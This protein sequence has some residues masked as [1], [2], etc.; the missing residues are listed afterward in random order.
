MI[1]QQNKSQIIFF[2]IFMSLLLVFSGSAVV[3]A[4]AETGCFDGDYID[5]LGTGVVNTA[6]LSCQLEEHPLELL[7]VF[8]D[9][10]LDP[11]Q[12]WQQNINDQFAFWLFDVDADGDINLIIDFHGEDGVLTA[13]MFDDQDG[14]GVVAFD[15]E[16]GRLLIRESPYW[17]MRVQAEDGWW[18]QDELTNFNLNI[19]IDGAIKGAFG[20]ELYFD[21]L[22]NDGLIDFSID[23]MD[24]NRNG[25]PETQIIQAT[26]PV[27][28]SSGI[29]RTLL[30]V[31][32]E[33]DEI[34]PTAQLPWP[35]LNLDAP[36]DIVKTYNSGLAPIQLDWAN[37]QIDSLGEFVASRGNEGNW[38]TYS[39]DRLG[40]DPTQFANFEAPF[41]FY[42]LAD[43]GDG[44]PELQIR[45]EHYPADDGFMAN[46]LKRPLPYTNQNVRYSWDQ[47]NDGFWDYKIDTIGRVEAPDTIAIGE[48][49]FLSFNTDT[50]PQTIVQ[51]SWDAI[52]FVAA[53]N[54]YPSTEGIYEWAADEIRELWITGEDNTVPEAFKTLPLGMRG[55][56]SL[57]SVTAPQLYLS[58]I[59]GKLH[60]MQAN[61][62]FWQIN[63]TQSLQ[64]ANLDRDPYL[65]QWV[66]M[67]R[68]EVTERLNW[69]DDFLL[70]S[71][72]DQLLIKEI[73]P[74]PT[75]PLFAP[76][77]TPEAWAVL[78]QTLANVAFSVDPT[79]LSTAFDQYDGAVLEMSGI[80]V[81]QIR[82]YPNGFQII[83]TVRPNFQVSGDLPWDDSFSETG[84]VQLTYDGRWQIAPHLA[85]FVVDMQL[86]DQPIV[87]GETIPI[88]ISAELFDDQPDSDYWLMLTANEGP[89]LRTSFAGTYQSV[90]NWQVD[91]ETAVSLRLWVEDE[92]GAVLTETAV[93]V[94]VAPAPSE[95]PLNFFTTSDLTL[96]LGAT[97]LL[98]FAGFL[99]FA[100]KF[101]LNRNQEEVIL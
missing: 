55:D 3:A 58:P 22:E 1:V 48:L 75:P 86:P 11:S 101:A 56:Y 96:Y 88:Q 92:D 13:S 84:A 7:I 74:L 71:Q 65:D 82:P 89:L 66:Q 10:S 49:Q 37:G 15:V 30:M 24:E 90:L 83:G 87:A 4:Q 44:M 31:N 67:S 52:T 64:I 47:D 14:D 39:I 69:Q 77:D 23:V 43:D 78:E 19:Q 6:V 21:A 46:A 62:G 29:Y 17:S 79:D 34:L 93:P 95:R 16:N 80:D 50:L 73:G 38:F 5:W 61:G 41:A 57:E 100:A 28:G 27:S 76:P 2:A 33:D 98:F 70:F 53:E 97:M 63:N 25:R 9:D 91:D 51:S 68:G 20:A 59:D 12:P 60:L 40:D 81:Q 99:G 18:Q 35:Y 42:D 36:E 94:E 26:P 45:F 8:R 32:P 54:N 72:N 85:D